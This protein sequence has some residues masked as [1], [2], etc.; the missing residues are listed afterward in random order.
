MET[1]KIISRIVIA[2]LFA[3]AVITGCKKS[4]DATG[5][6][7]MD[8]M[9]Q[10]SE[11]ANDQS[12]VENESN[13]C[14]DDA[15]TALQGVSTTRD[16]E[17]FSFCNIII[18]SSQKAVGIIVLNYV[19]NNCANTR[20]RSGSITI[21]LPYINGV[22]TRFKEV[23]AMVML[24]FNNYK[25]ID[26]SNGKSLTFNGT[27]SITNVNG[28]LLI[29]ITSGNPI[30]HKIRANMELTF[31]DGTNRTWGAARTRTFTVANN[32][33][34][35]SVTGDTTID[36]YNNIAMWG[37]NRNGVSFDIAI[38][39]P[40]VYDIFGGSCLFKPY[41]GVR[42]HYKL[43]HVITVTYGVDANGDAVTSGCPYGFRANWIN[44][45]GVAKQIVKSY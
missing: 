31:D 21:Q 37:T 34:S 32:I 12:R 28:G 26:L 43:A 11:S 33:V 39:T 41:S 24:T 13:L 15:N 6:K 10:Q 40:V 18:D 20:L 19:G 42:V 29:N 44:G 4:D 16:M 7:P 17:S 23:G 36:N 3:C 8:D 9:L 25:V 22:V 2:M 27:H 14:M 38:T 5:P 35:A 45:Q 1:K 30:V